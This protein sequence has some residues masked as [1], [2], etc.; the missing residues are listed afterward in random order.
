MAIHSTWRAAR[1]E[2]AGSALGQNFRLGLKAAAAAG[3]AGLMAFSSAN[4]QEGK[5]YESVNGQVVEISESAAQ[6]LGLAPD[7]WEIWLF[8]RNTTPT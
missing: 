4:A 2:L 8:R 1:A 3:I 7:H 6:G 5:F